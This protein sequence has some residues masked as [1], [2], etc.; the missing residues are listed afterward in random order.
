MK[1]F[2][3]NGDYKNSNL[4][5]KHKLNPKTDDRIMDQF[6]S[7]LEDLIGKFDTQK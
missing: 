7:E 5:E 1:T 2:T 3:R 4:R 6:I